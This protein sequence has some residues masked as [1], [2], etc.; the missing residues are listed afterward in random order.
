MSGMDMNWQELKSVVHFVLPRMETTLAHPV[1]S[2]DTFLKGSAREHSFK[3]LFLVPV[4][5]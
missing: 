3:M 5:T 4:L 2:K 1:A